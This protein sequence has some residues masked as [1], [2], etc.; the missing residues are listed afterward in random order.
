MLG[1]LGRVTSKKRGKRLKG[2]HKGHRS[3][4]SGFVWVLYFAFLTLL[5][6]LP[7]WLFTYFPT[8]DGPVHLGSAAVLEELAQ[9]DAPFL[10]TFFYPQWRVATNQLYH[11]LLVVLGSVMPLLTAEKLIL[12]FYVVALPLA[13]LFAVRRVRGNALAVFLVFPFIYSY[14][15][16]LGL[17]NLALGLVVFTV[18]VGVYFSYARRPTLAKGAGLALLLLSS[19]FVHVVAAAS[20]LLAI[21][22]MAAFKLLAFA[23]EGRDETRQ[24]DTQQ[25]F[26]EPP[27]VADNRT[28]R[29]GLYT[30]S[31]WLEFGAT[32]LTFVPVVVLIGAFFLTTGRDSTSDASLSN[33]VGVPTMVRTFL[34]QPS[35]PFEVG[36]RV[37]TTYTYA[38]AFATLP[39]NLLFL[40]LAGV[41]LYRTFVGRRPRERGF[42]DLVLPAVVVFA[43][44]VLWSPR[45][46]GEVGLLTERFL[47]FLY[48]LFVLWLSSKPLTPRLWQHA[49]LLGF[50]FAA[51]SLLYHLPVYA[52]FNYDLK[53]YVSAAQS[54]D[55]N[56]TVLAIPINNYNRDASLENGLAEMV[57]EMRL[58]PFIGATGYIALERTIVDLRNYQARKDYFPLRLRPELSPDLYLTSESV[59]DKTSDGLSHLEYPPFSIDL[60][61]YEAETGCTVDYVLF[62]GPFERLADDI[63]PLLEQLQ[64]YDLVY[65]SEPRGLMRVY[66][67]RGERRPADVPCV[68]E[69]PT[70][71]TP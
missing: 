11:G 13:V 39:W 67:R 50:A 47:P 70:A 3:R 53:E 14:I 56:S 1:P 24:G 49:A 5:Y 27:S 4:R 8:A 44:V 57:P 30:R 31:G 29:R 34:T 7:L 58:S 19:Y 22:V 20:A 55:D 45:R 32:V 33:F 71:T 6:L 51:A 9:G 16:L 59:P 15:V 61:R 68:P 28:V 46:L 42:G 63:A 21:G 40:A 38:D 62:W 2:H 52:T 10:S 41:A 66:E 64:P 35:S 23:G 25:A 69:Q 17:Y 60:S 36:E 37:L 12:S 65:V 18:T 48:L 54:I 43:L 26:A